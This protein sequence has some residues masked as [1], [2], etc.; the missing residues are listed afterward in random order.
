MSQEQERA[1]EAT[2]KDQKT[3]AKAA[4]HNIRD[5]PAALQQEAQ[6]RWGV[7]VEV[8]P[9]RQDGNYKGPVFTSNDYVAQKVGE[10]SVVIHRKQ[11]INFETGDNLKKRA[12]ENRLNDTS[13]QIRYEGKEGKAYFHDA[14]RAAIDEM[15]YR[16]K[17]TAGEL[18]A[19]KPKVLATFTKQVDEVKDAMVEKYREAK[20][21]QFEQRTH[22]QPDRG[23]KTPERAPAAAER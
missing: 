14:N 19:D 13:L 4:L 17:K 2:P 3:T 8:S 20:N 6:A 23:A 21:K 1:P 22:N 9:S 18:Y 10:K 15:A 7:G 5:V 11:D 16:M 12:D